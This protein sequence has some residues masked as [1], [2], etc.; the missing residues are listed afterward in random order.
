MD[1][2]A[3]YGVLVLDGVVW[4]KIEARVS[5]IFAPPSLDILIRGDSHS[6]NL[7]Y[8]PELSA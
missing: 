4:Q 3:W 7:N 1:V 6:L 5:F 2:E 8:R